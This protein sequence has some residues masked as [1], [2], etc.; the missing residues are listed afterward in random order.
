MHQR[1]KVFPISPPRNSNKIDGTNNVEICITYLFIYIF[2]GRKVTR[3][4][5]SVQTLL[6]LLC[7]V[8]FGGK[9][10]KL[11]IFNVKSYLGRSLV[12]TARVHVT[13]RGSLGLVQKNTS[14]NGR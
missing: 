14:C 5:H 10:A 11:N 8:G 7:L 3:E 13:R 2:S 12:W 6:S 9:K 1:C 4:Q